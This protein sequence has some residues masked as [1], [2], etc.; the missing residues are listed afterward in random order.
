MLYL[1]NSRLV[2][3]E[4]GM[5]S[6]ELEDERLAGRRHRPND[7]YAAHLLHNLLPHLVYILQTIYKA[8]DSTNHR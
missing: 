2:N 5:H 3:S 8:Q 7:S 4:V 6:Q 1:A